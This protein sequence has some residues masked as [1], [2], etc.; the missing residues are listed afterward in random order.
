[1]SAAC[2]RFF[3]RSQHGGFKIVRHGVIP[4]IEM[5][6]TGGIVLLVL[7]TPGDSPSSVYIPWVVGAW[8][9]IG[10]PLALIVGGT[11]VATEQA[12]E[13]RDS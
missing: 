6:I 3:R 8:L 10:I 11:A 13:A 1:V 2:I 5:L 7:F 12:G 4:A 9:L